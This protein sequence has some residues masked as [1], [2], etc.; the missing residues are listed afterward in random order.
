MAD[1]E[2]CELDRS[3][4]KAISTDH[5]HSIQVQ[6]GLSIKM[7]PNT[8]GVNVPHWTCKIC[9]F[10]S[11]AL[12]ADAL[13]DQIYFNAACGIRYRWLFLAKSHIAAVGSL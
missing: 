2:I 4:D 6:E 1:P 13:P 7:I 5:G 11:R 12:N 10:R 9:A 8:H 3:A